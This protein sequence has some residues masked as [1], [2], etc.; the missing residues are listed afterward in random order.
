[1]NGMKRPNK[2]AIVVSVALVGIAV[3]LAAGFAL[4]PAILERWYIWELGSEDKALRKRAADNLGEMKS[5]RALPQ[6]MKLFREEASTVSQA[7]VQIRR[8]AVPAL[9]RELKDQDGDRTS[10]AGTLSSIGPEA[11]EA[12]P[13]LIETLRRQDDRQ[14]ATRDNCVLALARIAP[15]SKAVVRALVD[16][17]KD[18]N[19]NVRYTA[20]AW[21]G[22]LGSVAQE[23]IP[24]L[25]ETVKDKHEFVRRHAAEALKKIQGE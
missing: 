7:L 5:V 8:P 20:A 10:A 11:R 19:E 12:V 22:K 6:L 15:E 14:W 24:A 3:F 21:L 25:K 18:P 13:V 23:A 9:I 2:K 4:K 1:M 16:A 17:L